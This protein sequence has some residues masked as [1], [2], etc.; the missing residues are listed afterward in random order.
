M[1]LFWFYIIMLYIIILSIQANTK[2]LLSVY[3]TSTEWE[4][5][6]YLQIRTYRYAVQYI[7]EASAAKDF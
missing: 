7:S 6:A 3:S 1:T 5:S 4:S 2:S